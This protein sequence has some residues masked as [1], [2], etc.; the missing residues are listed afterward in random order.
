MEQ[1]RPGIVQG[2]PH[3]AYPI[4]RKFDITGNIGCRPGHTHRDGL[5][6]GLLGT[7]DGRLL[8]GLPQLEFLMLG[9]IGHVFF[10]KGAEKG[11]G[12]AAGGIARQ[13]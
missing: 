5:G 6:Q 2:R 9:Q 3:K 8:E 10:A 4:G 7:D 13:P 12:E 1:L 11:P